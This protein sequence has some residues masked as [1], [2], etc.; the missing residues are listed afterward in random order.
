LAALVRIIDTLGPSTIEPVIASR[1]LPHRLRTYLRGFLLDLANDP[2]ARP[3][4][5]RALVQ[6]F[7]AVNDTSYDDIRA[8][9]TAVEAADFLALR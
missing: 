8:M 6:G 9:L 1:R 4:L 5:D 3:H 7:E 2:V